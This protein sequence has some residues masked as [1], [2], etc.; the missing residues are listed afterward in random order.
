MHDRCRCLPCRCANARYESARSAARRAGQSPWAPPELVTRVRRKL[1]ELRAAGIGI[2][3]IVAASGLS[4]SRL[5]ELYQG[6]S[7]RKDRPRRRRLK[8]CTAHRILAL[9]VP[10]ALGAYVP[11]TETWR[12]VHELRAAG[13]TKVAIAEGIGQRRALQLGRTRVTARNARAV[14][15]LHDG[16]YRENQRLLAVCRCPE[17]GFPMRGMGRERT[18]A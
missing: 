3:T 1:R 4:R 15:A 13:M 11:A 17:M 12:I 2:R 18:A 8:A 5:T 16:I 6:R 10:A 14:R 9:E 7:H